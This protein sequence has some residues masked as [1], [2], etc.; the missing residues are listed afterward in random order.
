MT[1][2]RPC[3]FLDRDGVINAGGLIN[4][5]EDLKLIDGAAEAI[6]ALKKAG[7]VVGICTNQG[8]LSEDF[9]GNVVWKQR[10]LTREKLSAIHAHMLNLLG[11]DAQP[12][13]IKICP[14]A[15]KIVC[16]CRKPK[17]GML[18]E[19]GKEKNVDMAKSFMVGDMA[20]DI[21]AGI[22][23]G[24]TPVFVLSGFEPE[25]KDKC[26][27]GTLVFPSLKEAAVHIIEAAKPKARA[28][29]KTK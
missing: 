17:G 10:P 21:L 13:F 23:A 19:A 20:T 12:D 14:H 3:V 15:K 16:E 27:A 5:P 18:K 6:A 2:K 26:P 7:F 4:S 24:V 1:K 22:D 28:S 25:Q 11:P 29:K 9:D 8:G